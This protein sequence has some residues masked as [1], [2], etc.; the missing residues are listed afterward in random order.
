MI[1]DKKENFS[2]KD[3]MLYSPTHPQ[4]AYLPEEPEVTKKKKN[5]IQRK[6]KARQSTEETVNMI[7]TI[8]S[9]YD[10]FLARPFLA[11]K[12]GPSVPTIECTIGKRIFHKTFCDIRSGVN[13]MSKVTYEY[14]LG[15]EPLYPTYMQL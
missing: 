2:F 15:N 3:R 13:I 8:Q 14:L 11:K 1:K 5:R 9:E 7:N 10:H 6:N 12:D 4:K